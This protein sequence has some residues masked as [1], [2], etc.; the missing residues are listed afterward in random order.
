MRTSPLRTLISVIIYRNYLHLFTECS[1]MCIY[2][3]SCTTI[4]FPWKAW[5]YVCFIFSVTYVYYYINTV[6]LKRK[7]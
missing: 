2:A 6:I 7:K 1:V 5:Y 4:R 3:M